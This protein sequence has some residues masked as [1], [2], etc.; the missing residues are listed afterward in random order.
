MNRKE[1]RNIVSELHVIKMQLSKVERHYGNRIDTMSEIDVQ[2]VLPTLK[3]RDFQ[4]L[5]DNGANPSDNTQLIL[6]MNH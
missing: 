4:A 2:E 1:V 6:D 3:Y 5:V